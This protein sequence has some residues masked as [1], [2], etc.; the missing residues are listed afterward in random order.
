MSV[1]GPVIRA[2]ASVTTTRGQTDSEVGMRK[3]I[4]WLLSGWMAV[5]LVTA[6]ARAEAPQPQRAEFTTADGVHIVGDFYP[7]QG[8]G[9]APLALLLH[10]YRSD[11]SAWK[12]LVGPLHDAGFAVL[13]IDMRGHGESTEP[14]DMHLEQRVKQRDPGIFNAMHLDA[15]AA[16]DWA[17]KQPGVDPDKLV[18][19]GASV[20]CSVALDFTARNENVDG[21]VCLSPGTHYLGVDSTED[22]KETRKVPILLLSE[23]KERAAVDELAGL[24]ENAKGEVVGPGGNHGTNMFGKVDG[25]EQKIVDFLKSAVGGGHA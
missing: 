4:C 7:A 9:E 5:T 13:A 11:R 10:M 15:A 6:G 20:G 19:V 17:H 1:G 22:I 16:V 25:I 24:A 8:E 21:V 2:T 12:P 3:R 18:V 23:E 14:K